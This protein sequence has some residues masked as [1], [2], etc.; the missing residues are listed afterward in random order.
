MAREI[1]PNNNYQTK[2]LKLIPSEIIAGYMAILGIIHS[3]NANED[4]KFITL[5]V[6]SI[7]LL[8]LVPL[9]MIKLQKVKKVLQIIVTS[10][11]FVVW[12]YTIECVNQLNGIFNRI[13]ITHPLIGSVIMILW[14]LV[15][16]IV[17]KTESKNRGDKK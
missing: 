15:I 17:I 1:K 13:G 8:L 3:N 9:Y 16:P 11:S 14:T 4:I 5:L 6:T 7:V 2:L 12:I 10:I